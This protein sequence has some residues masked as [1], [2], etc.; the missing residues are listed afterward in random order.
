MKFREST[1]EDIDFM[2]NHSINQ[3]VDRKEIGSIDYTYTLEHEGVPLVVGGF[4][5]ITT[6]TAWCS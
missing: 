6:T 5:M 3:Q 1:D 2:V 4:R